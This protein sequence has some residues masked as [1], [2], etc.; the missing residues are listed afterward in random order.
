MVTMT[1]RKKKRPSRRSRN[2][3]EQEPMAIPDQ[4]HA[5]RMA[6]LDIFGTI[7]FDPSYD[8]KAERKRKMRDA[9]R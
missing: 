8:Y 1:N 3:R 7:D 5:A 4:S 2:P 6:I 9:P